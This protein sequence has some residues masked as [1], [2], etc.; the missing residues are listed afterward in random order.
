MVNV[1]LHQ[2]R[3]EVNHGVVR[4][5]LDDEALRVEAMEGK[6]EAVLVPV[7]RPFREYTIAELYVMAGLDNDGTE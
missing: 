3:I 2:D 7:D 5:T 4:M 1:S 6:S